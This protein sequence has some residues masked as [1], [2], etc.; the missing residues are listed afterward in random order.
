LPPP[1]PLQ[2]LFITQSFFTLK[3]RPFYGPVSGQLR[4]VMLNDDGR[5]SHTIKEPI[6]FERNT[7]YYMRIREKARRPD[8]QNRPRFFGR[9]NIGRESYPALLFYELHGSQEKIRHSSDV[10][11]GLERTLEGETTD[12]DL[13]IVPVKVFSVQDNGLCFCVPWFE[14]SD[15]DD[16]S[17]DYDSI[18]QGYTVEKAHEWFKSNRILLAKFLSRGDSNDPF[19][20]GYDADKNVCRG[21]ISP[22]TDCKQFVQGVYAHDI[23]NKLTPED[24]VLVRLDRSQCSSG[25]YFFDPALH[26]AP[27]DQAF[28]CNDEV[29]LEKHESY[30]S[31]FYTC[32]LDDD[33]F[34]LY[35]AHK[36][37]D[38]RLGVGYVV[39]PG[40]RE[41]KLTRVVINPGTRSLDELVGTI[42]PHAIIYDKRDLANDKILLYAFPS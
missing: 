13:G 19:V 3:K 10:M 42:I 29:K 11:S 7:K 27:S 6:Q 36:S 21:F 39:M 14:Y 17:A 20:V 41:S 34:N 30:D 28:A 18:L 12:I 4:V 16:R 2:N 38:K 26:I 33:I 32:V 22:N 31:D 1:P 25:T 15:E 23:R 35:V 24:K 9:V 5:D 8:T 37:G 40:D